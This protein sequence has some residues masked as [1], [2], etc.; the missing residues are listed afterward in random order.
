MFMDKKFLKM[1]DGAELYVQIKESG[2][3]VWIIG[4]HGVGEHMGRHKYLPE[5]FGRDFNIFQY[6]LRGHGSALESVPI[7][8]IFHFIWKT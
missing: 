5:Q 1:R 8:Q 3:P 7:F 6:D 2:S 4:T